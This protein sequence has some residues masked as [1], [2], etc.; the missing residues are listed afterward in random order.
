MRSWLGVGLLAV[1]LLLGIGAGYVIQGFHQP[2]VRYLEQTV[3]AVGNGELDRAADFVQKA[4]ARWAQYY[5]CTAAL[6][7]HSPM[8]QIE[9]IFQEMKEWVKAGQWE[10]VA[11]RCRQLAVAVNSVCEDQRLTWWN[12]L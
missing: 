1:L 3:E 2:T 6:T 4:E 5:K 12:L 7:D 9:D 10:I 11:A 8:D